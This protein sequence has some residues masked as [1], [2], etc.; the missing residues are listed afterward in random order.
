[1]SNP[2]LQPYSVPPLD[3]IK[4]EH[5]A[6]ALDHI[7]A[8][9]ELRLKDLKATK[10]I[11]DFEN[12]VVALDA[13]FHDI[14]RIKSLLDT[15]AQSMGTPEMGAANQVSLLKISDFKKTVF[16]DHALSERVKQITPKSAEDRTLYKKYAREFVIN[17][18][19]LSDEDQK[20]IR[21]IDNQ[22]IRL[23]KTFNDNLTDGA[24]QQ[25]VLFTD[26]A[27]LAGLGDDVIFAMKTNAK[28]AGHDHGWLL[29]PERIQ[30]DTLLTVADSRKFRQEIF[31]A[32][33]RTGTQEPYNNEPIVKEIQALRHERSQL[34]GY[35]D[36]NAY[37]LEGMMPGNI[38]TVTS[39]FANIEKN[40][41]QKF[42]ETVRKVQAF[43]T[44]DG[45]DGPRK[46]EPWDLPYWA[47]RY[48]EKMLNFDAKAF[49][50]YLP[51]DNAMTGFFKAAEN[52]FSV[53]FKENTT[54][55]RFH[56]DVRTYDV[57]DKES[58]E[59]LGTIHA[60]LFQ[61]E[62]KEGGA[63]ME[64]LQTPDQGK[65]AIVSM[66][67]N[68]AKPEAGQPKLLSIG[69][70]ETLFHEG[71]H[72]LHGLLG[73]RT[74][75]PSLRGPQGTSEFNEF[76]S[77]LLEKWTQEDA[78]L[79]EF[80]R[81]YKTGELLPDELMQGR[82]ASNTF[83]SEQPV[84][85][86][87]Q[88]SH[89]DFLFH[90]MNPDAY[91]TSHALHEDADFKHPMANFMGS[92][93]LTRFSHLFSSELSPY[94]SGYYGYLWSQSLADL[95]FSPFLKNGAFDPE[96][97]A[98]LKTLY[99]HGSSHDGKEAFTEYLGEPFTAEIMADAVLSTIGADKPP[100][101]A[102]NETAYAV[103]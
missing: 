94:A 14:N 41:L 56:A 97:S 57:H 84:L 28:E 101:V 7:I 43:A 85:K 16:Q 10:A 2:L 76:F 96:T 44:S 66:N 18:A 81:H 90:S 79:S 20:R 93:P 26:P 100:R 75:H 35:A 87:I 102:R 52:I 24:K 74:R 3:E 78:C 42:E 53:T 45:N 9:A 103:R 49:S 39:F 83:F 38:E 73:I 22:L 6:P 47:S 36:Y 32:L 91:T 31:E 34:L 95:G 23:C 60:D 13:I 67:M 63:W 19:S 1:M 77:N 71:G 40:A 33:N 92:Y 29:I 65:P 59:L 86:V 17:G 27:D 62:H 8:K 5:F 11:P 25:A 99:G 54:S 4:P 61:R 50:E 88:N 72:A 51:L 80:A 55:P 89:R 82:M 58:G 21:A 69:E 12:T 37:A 70:L 64:L 68:M 15:F 48:R 46:L 98:R 30:I